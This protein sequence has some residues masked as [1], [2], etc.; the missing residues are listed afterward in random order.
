MKAFNQLCKLHISHITLGCLRPAGASPPAETQNCGAP[1]P[2]WLK[3][4]YTPGK[5]WC[6]STMSSQSLWQHEKTLTTLT[7]SDTGLLRH[8]GMRCLAKETWTL[9]NTCTATA[10]HML[11]E[12]SWSLSLQPES[13]GLELGSGDLVS[14]IK[15]HIVYLRWILGGKGSWL[16]SRAAICATVKILY[17]S[18]KQ[19]I[20]WSGPVTSH[21]FIYNFW[22]GHH[23][24]GPVPT[25][26][27]E[28]CF[29]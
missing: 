7:D 4:Y 10:K 16:T 22:R 8:V 26:S 18:Q 13:F 3:L 15:A 27:F 28:Q 29:A 23:L 14:T 21:S 12:R 19:Y 24:M 17:I 11:L 20:I 9:Y 5:G 1:L 25:K 6:W 2:P